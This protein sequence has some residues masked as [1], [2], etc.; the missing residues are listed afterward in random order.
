MQEKSNGKAFK[1]KEMEEIQMKFNKFT[2]LI[3]IQI[4]LLCTVFYA[5]GYG[6]AY[7]KSV[8]YAN[9]FIDKNCIRKVGVEDYVH[10][11][12]QAIFD[13]KLNITEEGENG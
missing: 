8:D 1:G 4:L 6:K 5:I 9:D 3:C 12:E 7:Q 10:N 2:I 11:A 13:F